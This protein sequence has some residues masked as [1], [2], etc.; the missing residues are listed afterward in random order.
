MTIL[1]K[2]ALVFGLLFVGWIL[3]V[4]KQLVVLHV[5]P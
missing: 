1:H 2:F 3:E 5:Y 4:V